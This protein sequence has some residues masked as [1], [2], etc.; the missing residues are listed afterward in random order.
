MLSDAALAQYGWELHD[1]R[2]YK[3]ME[4][5]YH[6]RHKL[7]NEAEAARKLA[8]KSQTIDGKPNPQYPRL[9]M[10]AEMANMRYEMAY[11]ID[12]NTQL[13]AIIET[14]AFM[15][16]RVDI[17]EGA[18]GHMKLMAE[19]CKIDYS[20]VADALKSIKKLKE[21]T[22]GKDIPAGGESPLHKDKT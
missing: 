3:F 12:K 2:Q 11:I 21:Q 13:S 7:F 18:Y 8:D 9:C 1:E 4:Q 17:L 10:E 19:T 15:H 14:I 16:Q 22:D 6:D 5:K 20:L